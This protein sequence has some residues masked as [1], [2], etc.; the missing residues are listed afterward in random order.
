[1][2][3]L[4]QRGFHS[5][6]ASTSARL[7]PSLWVTFLGKRNTR[8]RASETRKKAGVCRIIPITRSAILKREEEVLKISGNQGEIQAAMPDTKSPYINEKRFEY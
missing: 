4:N 7:L 1:M 6:V 8:K 5:S 3:F 2:D